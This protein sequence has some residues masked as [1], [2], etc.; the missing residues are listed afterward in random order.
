MACSASTPLYHVHHVVDGDTI[1]VTGGGIVRLIGVDTPERG[2]CGYAEAKAITTQLVL[3]KDVTLE[4]GAKSD[5]DKYGRFLRYV[6]VDGYDV[7][8]TLI[9]YGYAKA[10][11]DSRDG[12]GYHPYE[13]AYVKADAET[14]D[15]C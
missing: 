11:Y 8:L 2:E 5:T 9:R 3:N 6:N 13:D 7:G 15:I 10:R 4:A 12:Y 1:R 14:P